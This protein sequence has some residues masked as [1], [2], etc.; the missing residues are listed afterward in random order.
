MF[1]HEKFEAYQIAVNYVEVAFRLHDKLP[2][3]NSGIK[4]Q[5]KRASI[6]I[7]LNIAEGSGKTTKADRLR[8]YA[9]ARGSALECAALCDVIS[10]LDERYT[11]DSTQ[12]KELLLSV[13][14]ILSKVCLK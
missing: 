12:A 3:G 14:S 10:L 5:L 9:I 11:T 7:P 4:D 8:Y 2:S 6:S 1:G 13:V